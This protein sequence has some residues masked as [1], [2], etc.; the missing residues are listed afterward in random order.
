MDAETLRAKQKPLK[1]RYKDEAAAAHVTSVATG[2]VHGDDVAVTVEGWNG[3]IV[4]GLHPS[5]GGDG[6]QACSA[7][8]LLRAL[9]SC[10]G[11]TLKSV[12]TAMG[13]DLRDATIKAEGDWD[14]RGTLGMSKETPVGITAI[15]LKVTLDTDADQATQ[16]KLLQLTERFCVIYQTLK[17]PP[18]LELQHGG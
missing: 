10:T 6:S 18:T 11:V 9:V 14:A 2:R 5:T 7:D 8:I 1:D 17:H 13:V 4:A 12:A 16:A 3:E 15:R